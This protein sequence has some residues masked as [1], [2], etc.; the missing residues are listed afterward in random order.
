MQGF[1]GFHRFLENVDLK[2]QSLIKSK[3]TLIDHRKALIILLE[4]LKGS[5]KYLRVGEKPGQI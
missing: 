2:M 1:E 3:E 5:L 4:H